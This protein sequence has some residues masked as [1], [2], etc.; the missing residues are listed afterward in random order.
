MMQLVREI[1]RGPLFHFDYHL[2]C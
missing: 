1:L 2:I